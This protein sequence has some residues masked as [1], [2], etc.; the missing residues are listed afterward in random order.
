LIQLL[1]LH[2]E[3]GK[4]QKGVHTPCFSLRPNDLAR[5]IE[6]RPHQ[7]LLPSNDSDVGRTGDV[8]F[9]KTQTWVAG[10]LDSNLLYISGQNFNTMHHA[11]LSPYQAEV[12]SSL[13]SSHMSASLPVLQHL[14]VL[15]TRA[16]VPR[17]E[18]KTEQYVLYQWKAIEL[19]SQFP[20]SQG[21][22]LFQI[23]TGCWQLKR[24]PPT[25]L[26]RPLWLVQRTQL[27]VSSSR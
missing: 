20:S 22:T 10:Y 5:Q 17:T 23:Q 3:D 1:M 7:S 21:Y 8:V 24:L 13:P 12:L 11:D 16:T 4:Y 25:N 19:L 14:E 27:L 9:W 18:T 26:P 6:N 2:E 15:Q